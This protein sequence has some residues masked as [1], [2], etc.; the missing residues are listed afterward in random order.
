MTAVSPFTMLKDAQP[1]ALAGRAISAAIDLAGDA[2]AATRGKSFSDLIDGLDANRNGR[3]GLD[4]AVGL[5]G[6]GAAKV[7]SAFTGVEIDTR[8]A[9]A[10]AA[11]IVETAREASG[12]LTSGPPSSFPATEPERLARGP[13][14]PTVDGIHQLYAQMRALRT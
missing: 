2:R 9:Q 1:A 7:V 4:D 10:R 6:R 13:V 3:L 11:D 12:S 8:G 5:A 14:P